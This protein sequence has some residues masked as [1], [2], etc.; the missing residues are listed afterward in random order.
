MRLAIALTGQPGFEITNFSPTKVVAGVLRFLNFKEIDERV[1]FLPNLPTV[2]GYLSGASVQWHAAGI[3]R[4]LQGNLATI[5]RDHSRYPWL[6][7]ALLQA[8]GR[9]CLVMFKIVRVKG[10]RGAK[11][12]YL[13]D[14]GLYAEHLRLVAS[15]LLLRFGCWF[16]QI[17]ARFLTR[18]VALSK[19]VGGYNRKLFLSQSLSAADIDYI[20]SESV[21]LDL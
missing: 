8:G 18:K 14:R 7:V 17:E 4:A 21:C 1:T 15:G 3:E 16:T 6:K 9:Q 13:S 5:Y 19:E 2:G 12:I 10:L 20:Y 11:I